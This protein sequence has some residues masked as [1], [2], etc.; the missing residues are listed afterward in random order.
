MKNIDLW[1]VFWMVLAISVA[2]CTYKTTDSY[3]QCVMAQAEDC[4]RP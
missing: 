4:Q 3:N 1:P 2:T